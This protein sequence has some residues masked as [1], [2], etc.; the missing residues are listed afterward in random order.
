MEVAH[1]YTSGGGDQV[2]LVPKHAGHSHP[3]ISGGLRDVGSGGAHLW[4]KGY[5]LGGLGTTGYQSE[6]VVTSLN[7]GYESE[8]RLRI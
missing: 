1:E 3:S 2:V 8:S 7:L 5:C 6:N 4:S